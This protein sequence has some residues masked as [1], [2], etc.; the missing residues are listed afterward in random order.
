MGRRAAAFTKLDLDRALSV[1][2]KHDMT[3]E[4]APDGTI[5][6][7]PVATVKREVDDGRHY[8]F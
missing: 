6:I 3:V 1:A 5:R 8:D 7:V 4:V 2:K